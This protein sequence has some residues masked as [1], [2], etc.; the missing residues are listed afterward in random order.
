MGKNSDKNR[1]NKSQQVNFLRFLIITTFYV[2]G[3]T[4]AKIKSLEE[5]AIMLS[6]IKYIAVTCCKY[7]ISKKNYSMH[8]FRIYEQKFLF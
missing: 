8:I 7:I 1:Q 5:E 6:S 2:S 4:V 3:L